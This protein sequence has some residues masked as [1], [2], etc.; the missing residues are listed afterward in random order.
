M[1][2]ISSYLTITLLLL[3]ISSSCKKDNNTAQTSADEPSYYLTS[4]PCLLLSKSDSSAVYETYE[5]DNLN[6][7]IRMS[8]NADS[9]V[10][11]Y[12]YQDNK[13]VITQKSLLKDGTQSVLSSSEYLNK[14]GFVEKIEVLAGTT[15]D[16]TTL[17][18]D[19]E[20]YLTRAINKR[21]DASKNP[22][23]FFYEGYSYQYQGGNQVKSF[24][25]RMDNNG[26]IIDSSVYMINTFYE[27]SPG[28]YEQWKTWTSRRGRANRNEI[29][30]TGYQY[31]PQLQSF[32][33]Q[34]DTTGLPESVQV[35]TYNQVRGTLK[36]KWRCN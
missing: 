25:I 22:A 15:I 13:I 28:K 19:K 18:Y 3:L 8:S 34:Y 24:I 20:G 32:S 10:F 36:L 29:K 17:Y 9:N 31:S 2:K 35:S 30:S 6:R 14:S 5:Y 12:A 23:V 1:K 4:P 27:D 26:S 33:Y 16:E 11:T 21:T 7:I